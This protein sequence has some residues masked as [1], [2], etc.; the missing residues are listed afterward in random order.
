[1]LAFTNADEKKSPTIIGAGCKLKGNIDTD[2]TVQIHGVVH[3]NI[4]AETLIIGRGGKVIG[5]IN[6]NTL[7]LHGALNGDANVKVANV[8]SNAAMTGTLYYKTLN[9]T[10]N[11][12]L[13]CKLE[14]RK[15]SKK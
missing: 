13:E 3:G 12:G 15:E 4:N 9:I 10:A 1:M 8:F 6:A 2:H 7:F 5:D 11:T 14:K